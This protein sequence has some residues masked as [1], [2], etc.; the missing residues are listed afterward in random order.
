[1]ITYV[2]TVMTLHCSMALATTRGTTDAVG[3]RYECAPQ[4]AFLEFKGTE[5]EAHRACNDHL[6]QT[7]KLLGKYAYKATMTCKRKGSY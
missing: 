4:L 1:M 5:N 3:D 7:T 2:L 6:V